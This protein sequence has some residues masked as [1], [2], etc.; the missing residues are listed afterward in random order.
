MNY[1]INHVTASGIVLVW[2][3]IAYAMLNMVSL[4]L[5]HMM[6]DDSCSK[7]VDITKIFIK[8]T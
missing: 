7:I 5:L 1:S 8:Y 2:K 6:K 3:F 4:E